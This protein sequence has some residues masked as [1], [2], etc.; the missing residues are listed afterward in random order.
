MLV[1]SHQEGDI[2]QIGDDV[3]IMV[4]QVKGGWVRLCIDAPREVQITR[5]TSQPPAVQA[6]EPTVVRRRRAVR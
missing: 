4:R 5:V 2:L 3:R 1:I 6:E